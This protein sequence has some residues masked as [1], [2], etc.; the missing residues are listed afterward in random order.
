M[1]RKRMNR[2]RPPVTREALAQLGD[3][4]LAYVRTIRSE[5]VASLFPG[6]EDCAGIKLF[7]LHGRRHADHADGHTRG[8]ARECLS[9]NSNRSA[10][11]RHSKLTGFR[12]RGTEQEAWLARLS[13]QRRGCRA[14]QN[15]P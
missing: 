7:T 13:P 8:C 15:S 4:R 1:N 5:D 2:T 6:A 14:T 10:C 9:Q 3:G 11:I 12:L